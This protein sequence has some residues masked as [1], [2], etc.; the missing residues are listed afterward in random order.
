MNKDA[1]NMSVAELKTVIAKAGLATTGLTE[2]H[3]LVER[4]REA[5][6]KLQG[7]ETAKLGVFKDQAKT[8]NVKELKET[9][10]KGKLSM[11]GVTEKS[12]LVDLAA[13]ALKILSEKK[14]SFF[15]GP[16]GKE[17]LTKN[18]LQST[19][20]VLDGKKY[21]LVYLS[22]HWCPPCRQFTPILSEFYSE[23]KN[24]KSF[25]VVFASADHDEHSFD[26][27]FS[28]MPWTAIPY[29]TAQ[30][31]S[32]S[33]TYGKGGIPEL[34]VCDAATGKVLKR[35]AVQDVYGDP[36]GDSLFA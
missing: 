13:R 34:V 12:E 35:G 23:L 19:S 9:I 4:A 22:A 16:F 32:A 28:S 3:E 2:K 1:E 31:M 7:E 25:E 18:G 21:V 10:T 6:E 36:S 17:L 5:V 24:E 33:Q 14:P 11:V 29:N 27:Y 20:D 30:R 15:E 26:E 8:M